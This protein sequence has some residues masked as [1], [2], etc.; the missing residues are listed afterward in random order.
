MKRELISVIIPVYGVEKYLAR[1]VDSVLAQ[2]YADLEVILVDDGSPDNCPAICDA[3]AARDERV[4]V[5]HQPNAGL[6][7]A[8]NAGLDTAGG[9]YVGF[10]DSDDY[11]AP[12]MYEKLYAALRDTGADM[13]LCGYQ[14]VDEAGKICRTLPPLPRR[15]M[16]PEEIFALM[17][18]P[19][20]EWRYVTAVNRLYKRELFEGLRFRPGKLYEDEFLAPW[21]LGR[22][23]AVAVVPDEPYFYVQ[24]T[25]S[26]TNAPITIRRLDAVE[27][28]WERFDFYRD[29]GLSALA[30]AA[31]ERTYGIL[32]QM[33]GAV[34]VYAYRHVLAPWVKRVSAALLRRGKPGGAL[35]PA[36]FVRLSSRL[37]GRGREG[38]DDP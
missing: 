26:I 20:Q 16:T 24:H 27:A 23:A 30:D 14:Y 32:W 2:T 10:V 25:G 21:V 35:L 36:R 37:A 34:D 22:C 8:R 17:E 1:C 38:E 19:A 11:I 5:H 6:S 12:D 15:T 28:Y 3:Y 9:A 18:K 31:L 33:L 7:A 29:R 4:R 13:S